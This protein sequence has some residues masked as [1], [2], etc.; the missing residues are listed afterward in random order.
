MIQCDAFFLVFP[1]EGRDPYQQWAPAF[2]GVTGFVMS[3]LA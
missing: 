1:A 3:A 2:A